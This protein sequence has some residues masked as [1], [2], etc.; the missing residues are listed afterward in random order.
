MNT[1]TIHLETITPC[2]AGGAEPEERA[3]IRVPAIR[4]QLRWWFRSLGG[5]SSLRG[6]PVHE[7]EAGIFGATSG[8]SG[9]ASQLIVRL[10]QPPPV[11]SET[12]NADELDARVFS[13][14]GYL[15]FP[16]RPN[17]SRG[18][19]PRRGVFVRPVSFRLTVV[20]RGDAALWP[21]ILALLAV[22]GHLGALGF[23]SRRAMGALAFATSPPD[24]AA[25]LT[26]FGRPDGVRLRSMPAADSDDAVRK[27]ARWLKSWRAHGRTADHQQ[28]RHPEPPH[29]PGFPYAKQD[30]DR[31]VETLSRGRPTGPSFRPAL[32]L[33]IIQ[34]FSSRT[35]PNNVVNWE[36]G[37]PG[38]GGKGRFA[39][40]VLLRPHRAAD[41]T[42]HAVVMFVDAHRWPEG[43]CAYL[44]GTPCPV[45]LDLYER[46]MKDSA[47]KVFPS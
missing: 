47:L 29:N 20:W 21:D 14:K 25:A 40:P 13:D 12:K 35:R 9:R 24:L 17:P 22:F 10:S 41:G 30:H 18:V 19:D 32:G 44:N 2:F 11:S 37:L 1:A 27:L 36:Q 34:F 26:R 4:G 3:E 42:W 15:L 6:V 38:E 23:R 31:G 45:H 8:E 7:Q 28:A 5:F 43:R 46:M 16:L 39:S 33:P